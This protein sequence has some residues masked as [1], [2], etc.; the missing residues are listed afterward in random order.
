[1][2][3]SSLTTERLILDEL[4]ETDIDDIIRYCQDP[5]FEHY[6]SVPWPYTRADA[7]FFVRDFAPCSRADGSEHV[8]AIREGSGE[9]LLG[10]VSIR[11]PSSDLGF[12]LGAEHRGQGLMPE[13]VA[14]VM[15]HWF[16]SGQPAVRWEC[17]AG[18]T[19][20]ASVARK[21][22][23]RYSGER[24]AQHPNR[25]GSFPV[26]WHGELYTGDDRSEKP[27]WPG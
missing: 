5:V 16:G 14:A 18:N 27:G 20:S 7:E 15:D 10:V 8:W 19:A 23:L 11:R 13:A 21:A 9:P 2:T 12:W 3:P 17:V 26:S 1:M 25:D 4:V 24:D 6:L 22:G